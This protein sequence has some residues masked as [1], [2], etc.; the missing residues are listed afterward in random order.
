M[1]VTKAAHRTYLCCAVEFEYIQCFLSRFGS[2]SV[3]SSELFSPW[4][5]LYG[6]PASFLKR[7]VHSVVNSLILIEPSL[8]SKISIGK[9][10]LIKHK[11]L[12]SNA[13][14]FP[15]RPC[16]KFWSRRP[17]CSE[18][19]LAYKEDTS[20]AAMPLHICQQIFGLKALGFFREGLRRL[21]DFDQTCRRKLEKHSFI[22]E[23]K[24][25]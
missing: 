9:K 10:D 8:D 23:T 21:F 19:K 17:F 12:I 18:K 7:A 6:F 24:W 11:R 14:Y 22:G 4:S 1:S 20:V 16:Q 5:S 3:H 13:Q 2:A 15:T 25:T